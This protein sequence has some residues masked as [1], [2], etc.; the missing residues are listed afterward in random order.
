MNHRHRQ[1]LCY[2]FA[3]PAILVVQSVQT[4]ADS[5]HTLLLEILLYPLSFIYP[6]FF[7]KHPMLQHLNYPY[8]SCIYGIVLA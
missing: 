5:S 4:S 7:F 6:L 2:L 8:F 1:I 3:V